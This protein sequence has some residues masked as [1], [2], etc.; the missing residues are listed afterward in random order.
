M[1]KNLP[2]FKLA[3]PD[4]VLYSTSNPIKTW[5]SSSD[6]PVELALRPLKL[7]I[8]IGSS[9]LLILMVLGS[10]PITSLP[11]YPAHIALRRSIVT[12]QREPQGSDPLARQA[13]SLFE[14]SFTGIP[15]RFTIML[16]DPLLAQQ[17]R[18]IISGAQTDTVHVMGIIMKTA[19]PYNP[20]W[21]YH[22]DPASISF[23]SN[24]I[25]VCDANPRYVEKHLVEVCGAF[26]PNCMWCPWRS[27]V[28]EEIPVTSLF[29]PLVTR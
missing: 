13:P 9:V 24:A 23:F 7:L 10:L 18:D 12:V 25:E 14:V 8:I 28:V 6:S 11:G 19:A 29:L 17:A 3:L 4:F 22:L 26:L 16:T 20:D 1:C 21:S 2:E 27:I 15:D 5:F